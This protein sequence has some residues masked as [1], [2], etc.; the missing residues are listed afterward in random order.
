MKHITYNGLAL[1]E[2]IVHYDL[3]TIE[4]IQK[5][6]SKCFFYRIHTDYTDCEGTLVIVND[7]CLDDAFECLIDYHKLDDTDY[8]NC[9]YNDEL[10]DA[11]GNVEIAMEKANEFFWGYNGGEKMI[12][13]SDWTINTPGKKEAMKEILESSTE[14]LKDIFA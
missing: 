8:Y 3:Q 12:D 10:E 1:D 14:I 7:D 11:E 13:T 9:V 4:E 5:Q 2:A 6:F